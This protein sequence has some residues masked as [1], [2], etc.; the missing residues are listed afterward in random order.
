MTQRELGEKTSK[1]AP[2]VTRI[3]DL[4]V[5][6]GLLRR[7][8]S[9]ADRRTFFIHLTKE[10][11]ALYER[12]LPVVIEVRSEGWKGLSSAD[13]DHLRRILGTIYANMSEADMIPATAFEQ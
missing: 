12:V 6:K 8:V 2:T 1:D 10:G 3:I 4:L 9:I 11:Q 5:K 7:Q 13:F